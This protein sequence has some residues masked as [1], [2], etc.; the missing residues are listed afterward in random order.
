MTG[1]AV[2]LNKW[3]T[4]F[5]VTFK[6]M[7][8]ALKKSIEKKESKL[9]ATFS[10]YIP[11]GKKMGKQEPGLK[12]EGNWGEWNLKRGGS[13]RI[14]KM[15]GTLKDGTYYYEDAKADG[16][17][18]DGIQVTIEINL[19]KIKRDAKSISDKSG[20][21][22]GT[23]TDI[24]MPSTPGAPESPTI[25]FVAATGA[26]FD[27]IKKIE[28]NIQLEGMMRDW[29]R[30]NKTIEDFQHVFVQFILNSKAA[31]DDYQWLKP[32]DCSYAVA[33]PDEAGDDL[34]KDVFGALCMVDERTSAGL[35]SQV[36]I[37]TISEVKS[38]TSSLA[39]S[40]PRMVEHILLPSA[41][42]M[43]Y[44]SKKTDFKIDD[45]TGL[46]ITNKNRLEW[47]TFQFDPDD[48]KTLFKPVVPASKFRM[49]LMPTKIHI[50]LTDV[51]G[52]TPA[53]GKLAMGD[54]YLTYGMEQEFGIS[55]KKATNGN[56]W[57]IVPDFLPLV[58]DE[59]LSEAAALAKL[60]DI[61]TWSLVIEKAPNEKAWET[62]LDI[63]AGVVLGFLG[64]AIG[65][66]IGKLIF[67]STA[68]VKSAIKTSA[69]RATVSLTEG[70]IAAIMEQIEE[71]AFKKLKQARLDEITEW[72]EDAGGALTAEQLGR[73]LP[74]VNSSIAAM[75]RWNAY[76]G[77]LGG[78][79]GSGVGGVGAMKLV[80][81]INQLKNGQFDN[82][83]SIDKFAQN[84][85]GATTFPHLEEWELSSA[86][87]R[88]SLLFGG[89]FK[90]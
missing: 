72:A 25:T 53:P 79:L 41:M 27:E 45:E 56:G 10:G 3:D 8:S 42:A 62:V 4:V 13:G 89:S 7:N 74:K 67:K 82:A 26:K 17:P 61:K 50:S 11:G 77:F 60:Q 24:Q 40:A 21:T 14:L 46:V 70:Q 71:G 31:R 2:N 58:E 69:T 20:G 19:E 34:S 33:S 18:L 9:P 28:M 1:D 43:F 47:P 35:S 12:V 6:E 85:M 76:L 90:S 51:T 5:S 59:H 66:G 30:Q 48:S 15:V 54:L 75:N 49:T 52:T 65:K 87:I 78:V 63:V 39:I 37:N 22:G 55:L 36:S 38:G 88:G 86:Q 64:G 57:V 68:A 83:L 23:Q 80:D 29:C 73:L 81:Y 44:G 16:M 84:C 32:S